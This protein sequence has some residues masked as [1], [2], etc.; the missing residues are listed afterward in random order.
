MTKKSMYR[1]EVFNCHEYQAGK[2]IEEVKK[3]LGLERIVKLSSNENPY[4]PSPK[5]LEAIRAEMSNLSM[6]P[7]RTYIELKEAIARANGVT[8][9]NIVVGSGSVVMIQIIPQLYV[10]PGDE[11][12]CV[13]KT[14]GRFEEASN[15]MG[16]NMVIV[17]LKNYTHDLEAMADAITDKTKLIWVCNPNNPTGTIVKG[18]E[19]EKFL[20][21]VP[22]DVVVVFDEAYY[23]YADDPDYKSALTFFKQ[24]R[25]NIIVL[26]TFSKAYGMAGIRLGYAIVTKEVRTLL[27]TVQEP[28]NLGRIPIV[29]GP[30]ALSD[31]EWVQKCV[32]DAWKEK[33]YLY[34]EF[35]KLGFDVIPSNTNFVM[36]DT[37]RD[38]VDLFNK[39][40]R[41]GVLVRPAAG[42]GL[43][44]HIRVTIGTHPDNEALISALKEVL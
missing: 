19:I 44:T 1:P 7:E 28:F 2:T 35:E 9:E 42:W 10:N 32:Q 38:C 16:A 17:P 36:A 18:Y 30:A 33:K 11:V 20:E 8:I 6:Y 13:D 31:Q 25:K 4:G 37:K 27:D 5:V 39:L 21:K 3:E 15:L 43:N 34:E 12:I 22:D 14:F 41:K 24:G 29:T 40:M 26:R 23:E